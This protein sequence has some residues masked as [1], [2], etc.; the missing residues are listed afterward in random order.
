MV[1]IALINALPI[2]S[3]LDPVASAMKFAAYQRVVDIKVLF[4]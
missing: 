1:I 3:P 2:Q 4:A